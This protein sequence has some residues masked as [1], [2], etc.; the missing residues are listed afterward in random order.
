M[1]HTAY[2]FET[3]TGENGKIELAV[4]APAGTHVEVFVVVPGTGEFGDEL[5]AASASST[6]F[7]D[8]P[9]D[10]EDWNNA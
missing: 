3:E 7:W 8:N 9:I 1:S 2:K 5:A 10:D 4:P 6:D